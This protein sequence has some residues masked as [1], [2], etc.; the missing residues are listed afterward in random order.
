[1]TQEQ[2]TDLAQTVGGTAHPLN[3]FDHGDEWY[4]LGE[5]SAETRKR[6]RW[7]LREGKPAIVEAE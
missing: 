5:V 6:S 2:A 3:P 7:E 1:M 4:V